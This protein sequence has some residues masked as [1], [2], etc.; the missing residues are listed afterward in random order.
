MMRLHPSIPALGMEYRSGQLSRREFL[1]RAT[2]LGASAAALGALG[3]PRPLA[4][5]DAPRRASGGTLRIQQDVRALKDPRTMDWPEIANVTRGWLEYLVEYQR[6][7]SVRG[8]LLEDW[9][10]NA[11]ATEYLL[12]IRPGVRWSDG[13]EFTAQDVARMFAYWCEPE[14]PGN[15]MAASLSSLSDP[16]MG[17]LREGAVEIVDPM[18]VRLRPGS[19]DV[20]LIVA[21]ADYPAAV[22][23]PGFTPET[24]LENPVGTGPY[25][26]ELISTGERAILV[27]REGYDWW[28]TKVEGFGPATLERIEFIDLGTDPASWVAAIEDDRVDMLYENVGRF[29]DAA[30]ELGW[31]SSRTDTASTVVLRGNQNADVNGE[32]L[33]ADPRIRRGL[34]LAIDNAICL[35]LG[36]GD[37][38]EVAANHHVAPI[39]PDYADIGPPRF[40]PAEGRALIVQAGKIDVTHDVVTLDDGVARRTG[41]AVVALLLDADIPARQTVLPGSRFWSAWKDFPLS[42]T[43]W[44]HRPL[45]VQTLSLAYR[46]G[47]VWNESAYANSE[48]DAALA[49]ARAIASAEERREV[50]AELERMLVED[51]VIVQPYWRALFRHFRPGILGA[52]MHPSFEIHLYALGWAE[53]AR[54]EE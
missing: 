21:L 5:Q 35:E 16:E 24:M 27:R 30:T 20:T 53:G 31:E 8:M 44:N 51:A 2:A 49:R 29:I 23:P 39:Q 52:E 33:Y 46:S 54:D 47:A 34:S 43:E 41:E 19:P 25:R 42:I 4:A 37:R 36:Y 32:K 17:G 26:P 1:T 12:K 11:D 7:G 10:V 15:V 9:E 18:R 22:I 3:L 13:T 14:V 45:G 50:M 6:D 48:F 28:G 40:A 38:G